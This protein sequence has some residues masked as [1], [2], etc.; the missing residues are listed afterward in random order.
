M[1]AFQEEEEEQKAEVTGGGE[2]AFAWGTSSQQ[3][4]G[5]NPESAPNSWV[6]RSDTFGY[7]N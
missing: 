4:F 2:V 3:G 1:L 5:K 6:S 7:K